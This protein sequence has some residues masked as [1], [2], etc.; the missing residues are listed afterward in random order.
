MI[1]SGLFES[2]QLIFYGT[3]A[4]AVNLKDTPVRRTKPVTV[5]TTVIT[6]AKDISD[7][8]SSNSQSNIS[9]NNTMLNASLLEPVTAGMSSTPSRVHTQQSLE[10][11]NATWNLTDVFSSV[12]PLT[13]VS[14][15]FSK[16][17]I[18]SSTASAVD[19]VFESDADL[20]ENTTF[21]QTD[22]QSVGLQ[23]PKLY[24]LNCSE[25]TSSDCESS[26]MDTTTPIISNLSTTEYFD[27]SSNNTT[28]SKTKDGSLTAVPP[29][30]DHS[31]AEVRL[32]FI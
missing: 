1:L 9:D 32:Q 21:L 3:Q 5:S 16:P 17:G 8:D 31:V 14:S 27:E 4:P 25:A 2:W 10:V 28:L 18:I 12:E 22:L 11:V 26:K 29:T 24:N 7:A 19:V 20:M 30:S 15:K 13:E 6:V 23:T